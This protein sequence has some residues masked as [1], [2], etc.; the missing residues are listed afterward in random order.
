MNSENS[1]LILENKDIACRKPFLSVL[2]PVYNGEKYLAAAID[3]VLQQPCQ[4]LELL[5]ADDGSTDSTTSIVKYYMSKDCRVRYLRHPNFGLGRNRNTAIPYLRGEAVIFLDHDDLLVPSFYTTEFVAFMSQCFSNGI[6]TVIPARIMCD[7]NARKGYLD[8]N[9]KQGVYTGSSLASW[10]VE[11][12]FASL[13]YS[14]NVIQKYS[15]RFSESK[16]EME[17]IFRHR[18]VFFSQKVLFTN[19]IFFSIR[20]SSSG[21]ITRNWNRFETAKVRFQEYKKL[22]CENYVSTMTPAV[23]RKT[24]K[25]L[26]MAADELYSYVVSQPRDK[27]NVAVV[28][29]VISVWNMYREFNTPLERCGSIASNR[30]F[31]IVSGLMNLELFVKH[32]P[33]RLARILC[34]L[35]RSHSLEY[36][37][38]I[39]R[40]EF[41]KV[42]MDLLHVI[43][44]KG[45][46][47]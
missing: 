44:D 45:E 16:P 5:I 29:D 19:K 32:M 26:M 6:E 24:V 20:R 47:L 17:T 33:K 27:A 39:C 43:R 46:V 28:R 2:L 41:P 34:R 15:L 36:F 7:E 42:Y 31:F 11:H 18:A 35:I 13:I 30:C 10:W 14:N 8:K 22:V 25:Q 40:S 3:S 12:E 1:T 38:R 4:D 23:K 21:Q 9:N 37:A